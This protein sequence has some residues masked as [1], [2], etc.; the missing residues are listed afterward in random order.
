MKNRGKYAIIF[1]FLLLT[2]GFVFVDEHFSKGAPPSNLEKLP[3]MIGEW[4]GT[5]F[6]VEER[7][8]HILETE[9]IMNRDYVN[10]DGRHVFLSVVYYPDN[11]IGF[12]NPE[13][14]NVGAGSH[15]VHKDVQSLMI[16][17][18][19]GGSEIFKVNRLILSGERG[20]KVILYFFVS[21]D[22]MTSDYFKFR[23]HMM[24]Q[25]MGFRTPSGAQIQI[26][27]TIESDSETTVRIIAEFLRLLKPILPQYAL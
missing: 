20:D 10:R 4:R 3:L 7:I 9:Y 8:K 16:E 15:I 17:R 14:C 12:H 21:G 19:D 24:K 2:S 18:P 27:S 23:L 6:P 13:S 5:N 26:H 22:Y 25:Q 1:L 11:K